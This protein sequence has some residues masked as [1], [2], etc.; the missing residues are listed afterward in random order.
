MI[1]I[2]DNVFKFLSV[3]YP[4]YTALI[5]TI[6]PIVAEWIIGHNLVSKEYHAL[7]TALAMT[8]ASIL[9]KKIY[10][11]ELHRGEEYE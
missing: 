10:Q 2:K 8:G 1:F 11:P 3:K 4:V 6:L 7:I 9:G 5:V